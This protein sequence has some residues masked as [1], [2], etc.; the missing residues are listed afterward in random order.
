MSAVRHPTLTPQRVEQLLVELR[1][2]ARTARSID[3]AVPFSYPSMAG[4][5]SAVLVGLVRDL[6]G[7]E[8]AN[9]V[10]DFL[11]TCDLE[12]GTELAKAKG[13]QGGAA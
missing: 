13:R 3:A 1:Q 7:D 9:K 2:C 12:G 5:M 4:S 10:H 8:A 11:T 6:A